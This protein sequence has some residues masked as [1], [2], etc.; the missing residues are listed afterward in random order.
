MEERKTINHPAGICFED[1]KTQ[2][3]LEYY[4]KQLAHMDPAAISARTGL[5]FD[6]D[7]NTFTI[8]FIG[9]SV[10]IQHPEGAV[11]YS[12]TGEFVNPYAEILL[13][14]ILAEGNL[15]P[16]TGIFLPYTKIG[17]G[18]SYLKAFNGR[19]IGRFSHMFKSSDD[20]ARVAEAMGA[21]S[22]AE[23]DASYDF[24]FVDNVFMRLILWDKD[25]EFPMSAQIL[26]SD[27]TPVS[28][29]SEDAAVMGDLLLSEL[30][31]AQK[32]LL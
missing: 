9:R 10:T 19:C 25:D 30:R 8:T 18:E 23:G 15:A 28:F 1:N 4:R 20:F 14:R 16:G 24:E 6:E 3:P 11:S 7:T 21:M 26:F 31:T 27:N 2:R 29:T 12:D 17:W 13:M 32:K 5:P 22:A